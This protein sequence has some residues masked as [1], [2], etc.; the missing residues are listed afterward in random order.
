M[1]LPATARLHR[2][3]LEKQGRGIAAVGVFKAKHLA[4]LT[5][6]VTAFPDPRAELQLWHAPEAVTSTNYL[7]RRFNPI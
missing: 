4:H 2:A 1:A 3:T 7:S 6:S 5:A